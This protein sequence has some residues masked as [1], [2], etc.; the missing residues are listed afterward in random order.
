MSDREHRIIQWLITGEPGLSS[1]AIVAVM[2]DVDVGV[3]LSHYQRRVSPNKRLPVP[4][5]PDDF[6]RCMNLL[7][8]VPEYRDRMDEMREA[9]E[10]WENLVQRPRH[11]P[12]QEQNDQALAVPYAERAGERAKRYRAP[13]DRAR[14][15]FRGARHERSRPEV[16]S[17]RPPSWRDPD[18]M[19]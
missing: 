8:V 10:A 17:D 6:I 3:Y 9:S 19:R 12:L 2:E 7:E 16:E 5:D 14:P 4:H 1:R 13:R 11:L 18:P 15:R